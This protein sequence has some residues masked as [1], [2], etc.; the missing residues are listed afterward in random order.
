MKAVFL[1]RDGVL[2]EDVHYLSV[3]SKIK[4]LPYAADALAFLKKNGF[5]LIVITNQSGVGRGYFDMNF[6]NNTHRFINKQLGG[7]IDKFYVCPHKPEDNCGCRKPKTELIDKAAE[8]FEIDR[9]KS[10][11]VGD[12]ETDIEL[13][14]N[15]NI[16]PLLVLSGYGVQYKDGTKAKKIF[17][18]L[19]EAARWICQEGSTV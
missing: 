18:N 9:K 8:D 7:L 1:D 11:V 12:K 4:I 19:Y 16:T 6:V 2:I 14:I 15:A 3:M 10:F 13:G 17:N 5:K